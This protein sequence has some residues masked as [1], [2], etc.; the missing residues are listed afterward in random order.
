MNRTHKS[1]SSRGRTGNIQKHLGHRKFL[2]KG[3][4]WSFAQNF[5]PRACATVHQPR[6]QFWDKFINS[7]CRRMSYS[8]ILPSRHFL[9]KAQSEEGKQQQ[10]QLNILLH[11]RFSATI[12]SASFY[13]I[14][15][16]VGCSR[17]CLTVKFGLVLWTQFVWLMFKACHIFLCILFTDLGANPSKYTHSQKISAEELMRL[18]VIQKTDATSLSLQRVMYPTYFLLPSLL[19][20]CLLPPDNI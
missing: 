12:S 6:W 18:R 8:G 20:F 7:C 4:I 9:I 15:M 16:T 3:L 10:Q 13:I 17:F 11:S 14:C 5:L 1:G 19:L 2:R